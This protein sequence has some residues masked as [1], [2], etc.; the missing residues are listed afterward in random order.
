MNT[1]V[2]E[3]TLPVS[4]D[5]AELAGILACPEFLGAWEAEGSVV[6]YWSKNGAEI[7]QQVRSAVS[8]LG[9]T[10]AEGSLQFHPVKAQDWNATWAASVQP[11]RIGR[12]IG[13]RPS[14]ATM[15]MPQDGVELIID[16]KQAFGTGHHATTQLILEWLEEV[17]WAPG[18]RVL[19]VGTGSGIL[20]MAALRLGATSAMGI[21]VDATALDCAREYA[22]V[23]KIKEELELHCCQ[24]ATLQA[25][26]FDVI[27]ANLDRKTILQV[28]FEFSRM[29]GPHTQL[30]VS[31]LLEEDESEIV[32]RLEEQGW[33]RRN[34]RRRDGW[35]AIQL[36]VV[37]PVSSSSG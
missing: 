17:T 5:A 12:R 27:L 3:L 23:N 1:T 2:F 16:P 20:A 33:L 24:M 25:Q 13:I 36:A 15:D 19:D 21:D 7:L 34:V 30:V 31:G 18:M 35:I 26:I 8:V 9:V 22:V 6:L 28:Y 32:Q 37:S 10:L 4:V 29:R 11:I 14:W